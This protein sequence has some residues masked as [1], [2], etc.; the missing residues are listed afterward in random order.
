MTWNEFG[1]YCK[2][3]YKV[4][5]RYKVCGLEALSESDP[6]AAPAVVFNA[7]RVWAARFGTT[8]ALHK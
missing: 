4:F 8:T 5:R 6:E 1:I 7:G 3:R 2:T